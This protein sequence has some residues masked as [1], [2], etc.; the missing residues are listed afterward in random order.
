MKGTISY[1]QNLLVS[2]TDNWIA[3]AK[4]Q[5]QNNINKKFYKAT[6]SLLASKDTDSLLTTLSSIKRNNLVSNSG[7][8]VAVQG[9]KGWNS[10]SWEIHLVIC[11]RINESHLRFS[12]HF[13]WGRLTVLL[14]FWFYYNMQVEGRLSFGKLSV[15][16]PSQGTL[17]TTKKKPTPLLSPPSSLKAQG[18]FKK[19][20]KRKSLHWKFCRKISDESPLFLKWDHFSSMVP[21]HFMQLKLNTDFNKTKKSHSDNVTEKKKKLFPFNFPLTWK[22]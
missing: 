21:P 18:Y 10:G 12:S 14:I 16:V 1:F 20:K 13:L 6:F 17:Q 2:L 3:W 4:R 22:E 8:L 11:T 7:K 15:T 19:R 9:N 5:A